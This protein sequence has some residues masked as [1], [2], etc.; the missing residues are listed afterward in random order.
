MYTKRKLM[1]KVFYKIVF[2]S[3]MLGGMFIGMV[4]GPEAKQ[5][6]VNKKKIKYE[7]KKSYATDGYPVILDDI[8]MATYHNS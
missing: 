5:K 1:K 6:W 3:I 4:K 2:S 8:E 7:A